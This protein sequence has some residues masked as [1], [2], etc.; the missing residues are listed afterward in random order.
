MSLVNAATQADL[1]LLNALGVP[2]ALLSN[3]DGNAAKEAYRRLSLNLVQPLGA[4][5]QQE[6][7]EKLDAPALTFEWERAASHDSA[8]RSRSYRSLVESGV[9]PIDAARN[10]QALRSQCQSRGLTPH[11]PR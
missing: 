8:M 9:D 2:T 7:R 3:S 11:K 10:S 1:M 4:I 6:L 5:A